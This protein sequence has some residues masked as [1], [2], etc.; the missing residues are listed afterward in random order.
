MPCKNGSR[1]IIELLFAIATLV[2]LS[3]YLR[4]IK[5]A[6]SHATGTAFVAPDAIGPTHPANLFKAFSIIHQN[7]KRESHP[8]QPI[9]VNVMDTPKP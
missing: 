2:T 6:F 8:W 4:F 5:T 1:K 7:Q 3:I 9:V